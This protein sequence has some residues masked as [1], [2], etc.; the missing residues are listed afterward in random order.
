MRHRTRTVTAIAA[1][2][3]LAGS[4]AL[5]LSTTAA[6]TAQ[7]SSGG[8]RSSTAIGLSA[9]GT[10]LSAFSVHAPGRA[11]SVG[12]V[13]GLEGDSH[14]VGLD[15]RVQDRQVYGV[16]NAGGV[17]ALNTSTARATKVSQLTIALSGKDFGVDFNP[18]A[19]R[20]RVISD[21]GQNLRHNVNAGGVTLEDKTLAYTV[22]TPATGVTAAGYTN[23]DLNAATGTTLID[24]DTRLDQGALQVP[25]NDGTLSVTG[26][27]GL[28][29]A[30]VAGFDIVSTVRGGLTTG[31]KGYATLRTEGS[32]T[33]ALYKVDLLTG[34]TTR[35]GSF[36]RVDV[37]DL[38]VVP[39][40]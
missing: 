29:A 25:A 21:T 32:S 15:W 9:S 17:Y 6:A 34:D 13:S 38:T 7:K 14:L 26:P 27:L 12:T 5:A 4:A 24:L 36:G 10:A 37:A 18:A 23:N 19:D 11:R 30:P 20:L 1:A 39:A 22:G 16:G 2:G 28:N 35:V 31:N 40:R 8:H 3:V 33:A